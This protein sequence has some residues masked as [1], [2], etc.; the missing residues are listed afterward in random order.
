VT[1]TLNYFIDFELLPFFRS[2]SY[3]QNGNS[4]LAIAMRRASRRQAAGS[5][6]TNSLVGAGPNE[7]GA[8]IVATRGP[9]GTE[10]I[11]QKLQKLSVGSALNIDQKA[12]AFY[13]TTT[14]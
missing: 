9:E 8:R 13:F 6:P 7:G 14:L 5:K 11:A 2:I 10:G 12:S 1:Y 4:T 3:A